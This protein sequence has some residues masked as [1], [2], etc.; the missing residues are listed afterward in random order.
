VPP[1]ERATRAEY[2]RETVLNR[3]LSDRYRRDQV[4]AF[5]GGTLRSVEVSWVSNGLFLLRTKMR[6]VARLKVRYVCFG[7]SEARPRGMVGWVDQGGIRS[8]NEEITVGAGPRPTLSF[9][10][11][12]ER[13]RD[14]DQAAHRL[15]SWG[16]TASSCTAD[17]MIVRVESQRI[18]QAAQIQIGR[19][20]G[21][22]DVMKPLCYPCRLAGRMDWRG[23]RNIETGAMS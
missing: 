10:G 20:L 13:R 1:P 3:V 9:G 16:C 7:E 11:N 14:S 8:G 15:S 4:A 17:G 23:S 22:L 12:G 2:A 6:R 21:T 18:N 19:L 5:E